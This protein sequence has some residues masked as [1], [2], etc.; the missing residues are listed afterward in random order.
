[1]NLKKYIISSMLILSISSVLVPSFVTVRV[2]AN[3]TTNIDVPLNIQDSGYITGYLGENGY[4]EF[5][6]HQGQ[7]R[8]G[9]LVKIAV[10]IG[11]AI[12]G[13]I[14]GLVVDGIVQSATGKSGEEWVQTAIK[15]AVGRKYTG[16]VTIPASGPYTCPGVVIDHSG[17]CN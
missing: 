4:V 14:E 7:E 3:E 15:N 6:N 17:I 8:N 12:I 16:S 5:Y 13:Y 11:K 9:T 1:M 10:H 2:W